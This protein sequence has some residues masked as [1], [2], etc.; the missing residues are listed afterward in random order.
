MATK[1][2]WATVCAHWPSPGHKSHLVKRKDE[3]KAR[4]E[5]TDANHHAEMLAAKMEKHW[6]V[7]EAPHRLVSRPVSDWEVVDGD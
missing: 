7:D 4:Q 1:Q 5:I 3:K 2:E 6:Y